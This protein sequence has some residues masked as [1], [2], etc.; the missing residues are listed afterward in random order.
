MS[1]MIVSVIAIAMI[2]LM[3]LVG[4]FYG[5]AMYSSYQA[6]AQASRLISEAEQIA[7]TVSMYAN[8]QYQLPGSIQDLVDK[9]YFHE[10]PAKSVHTLWRLSKGYAVN[11]IGDNSVIQITCLSGRKRWGFDAAKHCADQAAAGCS[12]S[13][14]SAP[15]GCDPNCM[16]TCYDPADLTQWNPRIH[17]DDPCCIDNSQNPQISDPV[18]PSQRFVLETSSSGDTG[19]PSDDGDTVGEANTTAFPLVSGKGLAELVTSNTFL[20]TGLGGTETISISGGSYKIGNGAYTTTSGTIANGQTLTLQV[21]TPDAYN[22]KTMVTVL[23][24]GKAY[25]WTVSTQQDTVPDDFSFADVLGVPTGFTVVSEEVTISGISTAVPIYVTGNGY[26]RVDGDLKTAPGTILPGQKVSLYRY[27]PATN[28]TTE[29]LTVTIG[30]ISREWSVTTA[31]P[32][33]FIANWSDQTGMDVV[34]TSLG[35]TAYGEPVTFVVSNCVGCDW[36]SISGSLSLLSY[37]AQVV[38]VENFEI[39]ADSTCAEVIAGTIYP[40]RTLMGG[41]SCTFKIRPKAISNKTFSGAFKVI[42]EKNSV[43]IG[44][45]TANL[46]GSASGFIRSPGLYCWGSNGYGQLG[47]ALSSTTNFTSPVLVG[48]ESDRWTGGATMVSAGSSRT[49]AIR[50]GGGAYC[51]GSANNGGLGDGTTISRNFPAFVGPEDGKWNS[52]VAAINAGQDYNYGIRDSGA[53]YG[54]GFNFTG[55][56]G[57]GTTTT[58]QKVPVLVGATDAKWESG[59]TMVS[60]ISGHTCAIKEGALYCWG[61][62]QDGKLGDGTQGYFVRPMPDLVGP[63]GAKWTSGVTAVAAGWSHTCAIKEGAL[64][65]WGANGWGQ[66]GIGTTTQSLVPVQVGPSYA[67]WSSGV[68]AVAVG[69]YHTCGIRNGALYCWG[70]NSNGKLGIGTT[71][72]STIPVQVGPPTDKWSSGVTA[73]AAGPDF[74]CGIRN[75]GAL[76]CWGTNYYGNLGDGSATRR[77]E[78]VLVGPEGSKWDSGVTAVSAGSNHTCAV[79]AD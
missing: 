15:E 48:S 27:G 42:A 59:V 56:L 1:N 73:V 28:N 76:Y 37:P 43:S 79:V 54:W 41:E 26:Y 69:Q 71:T 52:G 55:A 6:E 78:P 18:F 2:A 47:A 21:T 13:N 70:D 45:V 9:N 36:M 23:I 64:Y 65:C 68:T 17:K 44:S 20:V 34:G 35:M 67:K 66:L 31:P 58:P 60:S 61:S 46:S 11:A 12:P 24:G 30:S 4:V 32:P 33:Q 39:M 3:V 49:C 7:G 5:G 10:A 29:I 75:T 16:R 40:R 74:T 53:L 62:A 63:T 19:L 50:G 51:W 8:E 22:A 57:D 72:K 14:N 38:S 77:L 25:L